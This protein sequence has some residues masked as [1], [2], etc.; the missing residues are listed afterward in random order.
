MALSFSLM[1]IANYKEDQDKIA[2]E[3]DKIFGNSDRM[4]SAEDLQNMKY[5]EM[6]IKESLRL[7]PSVPFISRWIHEDVQLSRYFLYFFDVPR[8]LLIKLRLQI[9]I[10]LFYRRIYS[11]G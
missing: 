6:C 5:L 11:A 3:L 9:N 4:P 2:D 1:M 8:V 7:Y 10:D